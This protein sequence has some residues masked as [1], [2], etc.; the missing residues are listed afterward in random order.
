MTDRQ[1]MVELRIRAYIDQ[2]A[3]YPLGH[4]GRE[5]FRPIVPTHQTGAGG[6][7]LSSP[8]PLRINRKLTLE[9]PCYHNFT[10]EDRKLLLESDVPNS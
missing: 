6:E 4:P 10:E 9:L 1:F 5:N 3:G 2:I 8:E 7:H